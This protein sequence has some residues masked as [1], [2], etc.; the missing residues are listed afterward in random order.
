MGNYMHDSI[1]K[2]IGEE[3][4]KQGVR[5]ID[6]SVTLQM[7]NSVKEWEEDDDADLNDDYGL[8]LSF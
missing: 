1:K 8:S 2:R 6:L 3:L 5:Y 7:V 4:E